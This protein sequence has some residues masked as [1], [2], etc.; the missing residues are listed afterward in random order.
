MRRRT[1]IV[2]LLTSTASASVGVALARSGGPVSAN[3]R[4]TRAYLGAK[5]EL[6]Q[7]IERAG[8]AR[9]S[10]RQAFVDHIQSDCA[11]VLAGAPGGGDV[12]GQEAI[13]GLDYAGRL[14]MRPAYLIFARAVGELRWS[15]RK[16][17][18]FVRLQRRAVI[19][20]VSV[21]Q[22]DICTDAR[23]FVASGYHVEPAGTKRFLVEQM[24]VEADQSVREPGSREVSL[25][26]TITEMLRSYETPNERA[27]LVPT[28]SSPAAERSFVVGLKEVLQA[29]GLPVE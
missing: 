13:S 2:L 28:P 1:W 15:S 16:L 14:V 6:E 21:A 25:A 20:A 18:R 17:T 10:A 9:A 24:A 26:P 23:Q 5:H 19:A 27:L 4:A 12:V 22:P 7:A 11:N 3:V 8:A 29:L